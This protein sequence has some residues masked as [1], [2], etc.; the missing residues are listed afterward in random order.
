MICLYKEW[1]FQL[2]PG[3]SRDD[4]LEAVGKMGTKPAIKA[5]MNKLRDMER[6]RYIVSTFRDFNYFPPLL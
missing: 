5:H 2:F 1:A 6:D 4:L 3:M